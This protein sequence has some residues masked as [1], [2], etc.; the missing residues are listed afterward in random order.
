MMVVI[1]R[2]LHIHDYNNMYLVRS[3]ILDDDH[4]TIIVSRCSDV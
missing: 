2:M 4:D 3:V 1:A